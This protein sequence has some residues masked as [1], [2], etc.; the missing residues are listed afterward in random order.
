MAEY[1]L[2]SGVTAETTGWHPD[3]D[4]NP[5]YSGIPDIDPVGLVIT[6]EDGC[7]SNILFDLPYVR[8]LMPSR[9]LWQL[10]SLDPL[11]VEPSVLRSG[12]ENGSDHDHHGWIH[13]GRWENV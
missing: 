13:N 8:D 1:D 6:H 12:A 4:L 3:R 10:V 2:G 5:Q 7:V 9:D 11:H